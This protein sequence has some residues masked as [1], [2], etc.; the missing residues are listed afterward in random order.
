MIVDRVI[1]TIGEHVGA[2]QAVGVGGGIGICVDEA[3][4]CGVVISALKIIKSGLSW[5]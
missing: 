3:A 2:K 5:L 1:L 4:Y